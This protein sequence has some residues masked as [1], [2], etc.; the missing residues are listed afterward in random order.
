M[1][2]SF[3]R[4]IAKWVLNKQVYNKGLV[5]RNYFVSSCFPLF[6]NTSPVCY[7]KN[8]FLR[9]RQRV[10]TLWK[11]WRLY[12]NN[13]LFFRLSFCFSTAGVRE[14]D[15]C[16]CFPNILIPSPHLRLEKHFLYFTKGVQRYK[17]NKSIFHEQGKLIFLI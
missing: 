2:N 14:K 10:C 3:Y 7:E 16:F 17:I 6:P 8:A 5:W 4:I 9:K 12:K 1:L 13:F 11:I 15:A